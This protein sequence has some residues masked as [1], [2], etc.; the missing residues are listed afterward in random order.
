MRIG[1]II[2][3]TWDDVNFKSEI[4]YV[5]KSKTLRGIIKSTKTNAGIREVELTPLALDALKSQYK[6]TGKLSANAVFTNPA[7]EQAWY[8][9]S[10]FWYHWNKTLKLASVKYRNPHQMRHTFI[11]HMLSLGN[12]PEVL[13][14]IVGHK[15][16]EMI[17]KVYGKFIAENKNQKVLIT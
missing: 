9:A 2:A 15:N 7:T 11:S 13:Y 3:L 6:L 1:E 10:K 14:K 8:S 17:Y 12:R 5:T 16:T 4:V